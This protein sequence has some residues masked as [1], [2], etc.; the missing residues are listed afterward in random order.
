MLAYSFLFGIEDQ[1]NQPYHHQEIHSVNPP[2]ISSSS[3]SSSSHSQP[4]TS[5]ISLHQPLLLSEPGIEVD[6]PAQF[7]PRTSS[8]SSISISPYLRTLIRIVIYGYN[9]IAVVTLSYFH[10]ESAGDFGSFLYDEPSIS[11][12][13]DTYH[14]L[15]VLFICISVLLIIAP[16]L[17]ALL[18]HHYKQ[19][20]YQR[21]RTP[22]RNDDPSSHIN[23]SSRLA[24]LPLTDLTTDN[25]QID[26]EEEKINGLTVLPS[27][28]SSSLLSRLVDHLDLLYAVYRPDSSQYA[29]IILLR[30]LILIS[31]FVFTPVPYT[32]ASLT[33]V[34]GFCLM[35]H[36]GWPPYQR[37]KDN[38]LEG[39]TLSALFIQTAAVSVL[40]LPW[41]SNQT[42]AMANTA[43]AISLI[44][45][46]IIFPL[47]IL[48]CSAC[49]DKYHQFKAGKESV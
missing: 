17:L 47:C 37:T 14:S 48:F 26:H 7:H 27:S 19:Q 11:C 46:L 42:A 28:S 12:T 30:R 4:V 31:V 33:V 18:F 41:L 9:T 32:F 21:S 35:I 29:V 2:S 39:M 23:L 3:S 5:S 49:A 40:P 8:L 6:A 13:S 44:L 25:S 24:A 38:W 1:F 10:C 22:R 15:L 16:L 36:T 20:I 43:A 34:N 45:L